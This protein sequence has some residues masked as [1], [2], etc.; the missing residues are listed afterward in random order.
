MFRDNDI[1]RAK[2]FDRDG[3]T[4]ELQFENRSGFRCGKA[5]SAVAIA[6]AE[7]TAEREALEAASWLRAFR[8]ISSRPIVCDRDC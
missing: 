2:L 5:Y 4:T 6:V 7:A 1:R 8:A 3:G